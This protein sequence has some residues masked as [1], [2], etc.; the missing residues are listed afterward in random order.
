MSLIKKS[1]LKNLTIE[2]MK[3]KIVALRRELIKTNSQ[4]AIGTL[5][6]NSGR[7]KEIKRT[8]AK[9]NMIISQKPKESNKTKE[10]AKK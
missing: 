2:Q 5:P 9:L 1:E 4:I 6:E 10:V 3:E 8:V 7:I